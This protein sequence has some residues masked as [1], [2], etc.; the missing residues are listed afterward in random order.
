[1]ALEQRAHVAALDRQKQELEKRLQRGLPLPGEI[2]TQ[3][4]RDARIWAFMN[5]KPTES[6]EED[7]DWDIED[8]DEDPSTW[9]EDDEDDGRKG[10]PL[11]D[12]DDPEEL[13]SIIR[14]DGSLW[15]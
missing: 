13:S 8:D 7:E 4:E 10:Q 2:L 3:E 9:F 1:M 15:G 11:V 6:D 12:P 14:V 5:A